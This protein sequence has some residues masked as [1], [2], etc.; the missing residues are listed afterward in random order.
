M[1]TGIHQSFNNS[2]WPHAG[3]KEREISGVHY[4][5]FRMEICASVFHI[6]YAHT[7]RV[8]QMSL[9]VHRLLACWPGSGASGNL[10]LMPEAL[11]VS[12]SGRVGRKKNKTFLENLVNWKFQVG[13]TLKIEDSS[14]KMY[15]GRSH[16]SS[17]EPQE[18]GDCF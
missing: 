4:V 17:V 13:P 12:C 14:R 9:C 10:G 15:R 5:G 6:A 11:L 16:L 18:Q 8:H 3:R 1:N 7:F 2:I